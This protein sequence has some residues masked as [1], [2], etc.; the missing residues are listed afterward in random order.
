MNIVF[1]SHPDFLKHASM[2]RFLNMLVEGFK[3]RGHNIS[4]LAPKARVFKLPAPPQFKKWL[5][6][7]DQY[8]I[9]PLEIKKFLGSYSE[10]T[11]FVFTDNALGPWVP[12]VH[13]R[14]HVIHCHDFMAQ[15]SALGEIE[16]NKTSWSGRRYQEFIKRGYSKGKNFISVSNKTKHNLHKL[17]PSPPKLSEVVYNGLNYPFKPSNPLTS[18]DKLGRKLGFDL[19]LGFILHVGGNMW[20]KNRTG[21]IEIY[22]KWRKTQDQ[23]VPLLL[24]GEAPDHL[25]KEV[26]R[27]SSYVNDIHFVTNCDNVDVNNAY[28]GALVF[29]FPSLDEGFGWPIAEAMASGCPVI[30]TKEPPMTEVAGSAAYFIRRK[31]S[32]ESQVNEWI[33]ESAEVLAEV[34][35]LSL[36][37]KNNLVQ[38]GLENSRRFNTDNALNKIEIIYKSIIDTSS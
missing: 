36:E 34:M 38:A 13:K 22:T 11:L 2:P 1:F 15:L 32:E 37:V 30:T 14:L 12:L 16:E 10:D 23:K 33:K 35:N 29:L 18:R 17:L 27:N 25:L 28:S 3:D 24:L 21:V 19:N 9:F 26:Y 5:G 31:P 8:I 20:Y 7:I 6:Y 4:V